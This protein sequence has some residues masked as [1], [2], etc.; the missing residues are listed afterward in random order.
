VLEARS[1]S[2]LAPQRSY[3]TSPQCN[4]NKDDDG[5]KGG[6]QHYIAFKVSHQCFRYSSA[7]YRGILYIGWSR[8]HFS[9][10]FLCFLDSRVLHFAGY[11]R[12]NDKIHIASSGD[13]I[14]AGADTF[15]LTDHYI[16]Y[17]NMDRFLQYCFTCSITFLIVFRMPLWFLPMWLKVWYL[18]HSWWGSCSSYS[19]SFSIKWY[20]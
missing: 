13:R 17:H 6:L 3:F 15:A 19:N 2:L 18:Y 10:Y 11:P 4:T 12:K 9:V 14:L 1:S 5:E 16:L 20:V 7:D 8:S